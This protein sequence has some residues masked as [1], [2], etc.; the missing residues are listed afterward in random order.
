LEYQEE[1][2][3]NTMLMHD[4]NA[5]KT[6]IHSAASAIF[7]RE[8][9]SGL[10]MRAVAKEVGISA[11]AIYRHYANREAILTEIWRSGCND[12]AHSMSH[13]IASDDSTERILTLTYRYVHWALAQPEIF[14]LMYRDD[15]DG[16]NLLPRGGV[17]DVAEV[18]NQSV[19]VLVGEIE[20]GIRLG[21]FR[22]E[23]VWQV[24]VAIW[25]QSRGLISLHRA[26]LIDVP[27]HELPAIA[28][29]STSYLLRGITV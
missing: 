18:T 28:R 11:A 7:N 9:L 14:E 23:N 17:N 5:T 8:G 20:R 22:S 13:P 15:P 4:A 29:H 1:L 2:P 10:T 16:L 3:M 26:G 25:A 21:H 27:R 19:S 24:A 6:R 12:L